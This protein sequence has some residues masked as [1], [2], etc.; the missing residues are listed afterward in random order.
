MLDELIGQY[1]HRLY[2]YLFRFV[3][4]PATAE[5]LFQQTWLRVVERIG[6]FDESRSFEPW[7]F[8]IA[9]NVAMDYLRKR[10]PES[11]EEPDLEPET[12]GID[13]LD[14]CLA[15]ERAEILMAAMSGLPASYREV[16][17][18][19]FEEDMKLEEIARVVNAPLP[20]VKTR[21]R[22]ALIDLRA[23]LGTHY[24]RIR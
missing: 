6:K 15:S 4:E 13:A 21:L 1:Q 14:Q 22:R 2:R 10:K 24:E 18:L 7:L 23:R 19:R 20:T 5:D 9:H 8:A 16:L 17:T 12:A 11:L 3:N